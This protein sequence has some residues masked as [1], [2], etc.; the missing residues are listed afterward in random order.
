MQ[1]HTC[2]FYMLNMYI[3]R[4][5]FSAESLCLC[6]KHFKGF[7]A[8]VLAARAEAESRSAGFS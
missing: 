7:K 8:A 4:P 2:A 5:A 6:H 3:K 1:T